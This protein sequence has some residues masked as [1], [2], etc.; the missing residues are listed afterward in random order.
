MQAPRRSAPASP[1][2]DV[3]VALGVAAAYLAAAKLGLALAFQ[4]AQVSAVWPP[5]GLALAAVLRLGRRAVPGVLLGAFVANATAQE[6]LAVAAGIAL[7]N[8]LEALAAVWLLR[9]AGFDPRLARLRDVLAL[10]A[11]AAA[12]P[13]V[14]ATVGVASLGSG[15]VQPAATLP[16]LW[17]VWWTGDALGALVAAPL[18]L[19][20]SGG[21]VRRLRLRAV[22]EGAV[23]VAALLAATGLV[24]GHAR[25]GPVAEYVVFPFL[26][27]AALRFGPPGT[28]FV[29][30]AAYAAAVWGTINGH[31]PFAGGAEGGLLLLQVF[32]AVA[33]TTGLLLGA[34]SAEQRRAE[35]KLRRQAEQLADADRR[36]DEFLA[37]LAHELRNPLAPI[38]HATELLGHGAPAAQ[39]EQARRVIRRQTEHLARVVDDLLDVSRITR[40]M[41]RLERRRMALGEAVA[42]A[43]ETCR[44]R[45]EA[46]RHELV[47]ELPAEPLWLD[48][49]PVRLAQILSNLLHNAIKFTPDGGRIW[50]TAAAAGGEI[51]IAVR[52]TGVGMTPEV[53]ASAFDLFAQGPPPFDR[54]HG[55]L[56]L[57]LTLVRRLAELHGGSVAAASDGP[58]RGSEFVVR[59]PAAAPPAAPEPAAARGE[60]AAAAARP[61]RVLVVDDNVDACDSLAVLLRLDGHEVGTAYDGPG[62][63]AAAERFKPEVLLLDLGLPGLDGY[64]VARTLRAEP[65]HDGMRIVAISGYGQPEDRERS[66]AAGIEEHLLKPVEPQRIREL[67][68]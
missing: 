15:G 40:D 16:H 26:I 7:G 14:S 39:S 48:A 32:M 55:G 19:T 56:G 63:L 65:G 47:V 12:G 60:E 62:A 27:W 50:L 36:K 34:V 38:L 43:V 8:T 58:G 44:P 2:A 6:P 20:W 52:D 25:P 30:A 18:L 1:V 13:L 51:T 24:F 46:R 21:F 4:A 53:L 23:L 28:S 59:L 31:G 49:D 35:K 61:R 57:G 68:R 54:P 33:A 3:L 22:A 9:R 64:E 17:R 11:A 66:R 5:T 41:V 45:L 37:T 10:L 42:T 29:T 67:V